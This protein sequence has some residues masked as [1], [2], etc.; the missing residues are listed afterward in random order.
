MFLAFCA[1]A[2]P[3]N[4]Q[5]G[6]RVGIGFGLAFL[7]TYLCED[8]KL[9]EKHG[10]DAHLDLRASYQRFPGAGPLQ[11]AV[12]SGSIDIAPFGIAPLLAAWEK[13]KGTSRQVL[14]VSGM[15]TLPLTLLANRTDVRTIADFRPSDRIV[16]P[17]MSSPQVYLLQMQSEK[18]L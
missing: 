14:V 8:L 5:E 17:T 16:V 7:P 1:Q 10:K 6:V 15:T 11:D 18:I 4:A 9:I 13:A 12:V 3:T 2:G